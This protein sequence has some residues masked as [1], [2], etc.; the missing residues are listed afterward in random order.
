MIAY[1]GNQR[2]ALE[3]QP[4]PLGE[5][6]PAAGTAFDINTAAAK[7]SLKE[8]GVYL[9]TGG[10]GGIGLLVAQY[11]S[12][13]LQARLILTGRTALPPKSQWTEWVDRHKPG[14]VTSLKIQKLQE[15]ELS[16]AEIL[17]LKADAAN[18]EELRKIV[19][20]AEQRF[21]P[22][23]GIIHAAGVTRGDS[24]NII[25]R[26][27]KK[28][29]REQFRPKI[30]GLLVLEKLF[31]DK[32]PDFCLFTSSLASVLGGLRFAAYS[33]ANCFMDA[34]AARL[35]RIQS[36]RWIS[37]DWDGWD[38]N[39][40]HESQPE[41]R[42][43]TTGKENSNT[44]ILPLEGIEALGRILSWK[45]A[46]QVI[47]ST[48]DLQTRI[49]RWI[50]HEPQDREEPPAPGKEDNTALSSRPKL[51]TSF[52]SPRNQLEQT[53]A[54]IWKNFFGFEVGIYDDF[55][56]LGGDSLKA[57]TL[58]DKINRQ[59]N[60]QLSPAEMFTNPT[61]ENLAECITS[62]NIQYEEAPYIPLNPNKS[63]KVFV[64]PPVLGDG[65]IYKDLTF[66]LKEYSFYAFNYIDVPDKIQRYI[67]MIYE[68][69]PTGSYVLMGYSSGGSLA[70]EIAKEFE[71]QGYD[72][73]N[74]ILLDTYRMKGDSE[75]SKNERKIFK[76]QIIELLNH[77]G[78]RSQSYK[79]K[80]LEKA[81]K[82]YVYISGVNN[83]GSVNANVHLI[84]GTDRKPED[85]QEWKNATTK[86]C[87][88]YPGFAIHNQLLQPR[89]REKNVKL[90]KKIL[91]GLEWK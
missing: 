6:I 76:E 84:T 34:Y 60:V 7:L 77:R 20:R 62:G 54:N 51:S 52:N 29:C 56:E 10:L 86:N 90:L 28:Q 31:K 57:L 80:L 32:Q 16:G 58:I 26:L 79:Q 68:I 65:I 67:E 11:L 22:I 74:I 39:V 2:W 46:Y 82:Y 13:L 85:Y 87:I 19:N 75:P 89:V 48:T 69:Q 1:R 81:E 17:P 64:F 15:L 36:N 70:F 40:N 24:F 45:E 12:R 35:S 72:V 91:D 53:I 83:D 25:A 43:K 18:L 44:D 23:N 33:A 49:N 37:I 61:I 50:R 47:V 38:L 41:T 21:G 30:Q 9:I 78:I 42:D 8:K 3:Y 55:F 4:F 27:T 14:N 59:M 88:T 63:R 71:N 5:F 66:S 73:S